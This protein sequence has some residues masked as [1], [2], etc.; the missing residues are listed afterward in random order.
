MQDELEVGWKM[1]QRRFA[2]GL[3]K[4]GEIHSWNQLR[5]IEGRAM[6]SIYQGMAS[7]LSLDWKGR[8]DTPGL[9]QALT[10]ANKLMYGMCEIAIRV[11]GWSPALG[12]LHRGNPRSFV[13]DLVDLV[14]FKTSFVMAYTSA[15]RSPSK[16]RYDVI[17][18]VYQKNSGEW[19]RLI[20]DELAWLASLKM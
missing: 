2:S 6:R 16:I 19:Y 18:K 9:S 12:I 17:H 5:G 10:E 11:A 8:W 4:P 13:F 7:N 1:L 3:E 20:F 15:L 14:K